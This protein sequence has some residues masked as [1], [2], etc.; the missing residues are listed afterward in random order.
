ML[1]N[2]GFI[3][4]HN[5]SYLYDGNFICPPTKSLPS[6]FQGSS[7]T[8][9]EH[10]KL[11]TSFQFWIKLISLISTTKTRSMSWIQHSGYEAF[12]CDDLFITC[13][14]I[15]DSSHSVNKGLWHLIR[16]ARLNLCLCITLSYALELQFGSVKE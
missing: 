9:T 3:T 12:D 1:L 14:K 11:K 5:K 13:Y 10:R 8:N 7:T 2:Q 4:I 6:L 16:L 15:K